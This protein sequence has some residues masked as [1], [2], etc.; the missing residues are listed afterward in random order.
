ME[1]A[2]TFSFDVFPLLVEGS[3]QGI[4]PW[5]FQSTF[6]AMS[7]DWQKAYSQRKCL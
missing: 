7:G 5:H 2:W 1:L 4:N 3:S 6:L